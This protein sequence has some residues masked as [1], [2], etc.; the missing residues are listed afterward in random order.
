MMNIRTISPSSLQHELNWIKCEL[1][2]AI[3]LCYIKLYQCNRNEYVF[4]T[5]KTKLYLTYFS[6]VILL[7]MKWI[8]I[9]P[10]HL[11][12]CFWIMTRLI[13]L[14]L[15]QFSY[16]SI[17][18]LW[19]QLKQEKRCKNVEKVNEII[20]HHQIIVFPNSPDSLNFVWNGEMP[21]LFMKDERG[22]SVGLS[23]IYTVR[24]LF[25]FH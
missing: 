9:I 6:T 18:L 12:L 19:M 24:K 25:K 10:V 14:R 2:S 22:N 20:V 1:I 13:I 3:L 15:V 21:M 4:N 16:L 23:R 7:L 17:N 5:R 8:K 11:N